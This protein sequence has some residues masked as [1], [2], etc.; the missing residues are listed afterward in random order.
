LLDLDFLN[1]EITTKTFISKITYLDEVDSTNAYA[2]RPFVGDNELIIAGFQSAGKG[3][4]NRRWESNK[5]ENLTFTIKRKFE[6][7]KQNVQSVNFFFSYF[8]LRGIEQFLSSGKNT[9]ITNEL[10]IKWPN[11]ILFNN[12]KLSGLLIESDN[13]RTFLIGIGLNVNQR[14]FS[15]P[16]G[17]K[18]TSLSEILG[19]TINCTELLVHIIHI[20]SNNLQLFS[21]KSY[22]EIYTLWISKCKA[23]GKIVEFTFPNN[24]TDSGHVVN[25][26]RD[27]GI[28][29]RIDNS[30]K[31]FYS[32]D[33]RIK[34]V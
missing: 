30:D 26:L 19:R 25:V 2:K 10:E 14:H 8:L 18:T 27:G 3:R 13:S 20:F 9:E 24:Y 6:I 29:L 7:E 1:S 15:N 23:I 33:I 5:E 17:P 34:N 12:R 22:N 32:G 4:L 11:D 28:V 31:T 21:T 16:Y